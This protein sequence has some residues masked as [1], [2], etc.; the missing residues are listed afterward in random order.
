[1]S[2]KSLRSTKKILLSHSE[3]NFS[4]LDL[5]K[6]AK[7]SWDK[8]S[9]EFDKRDHPYEASFLMLDSAKA[10]KLLHWQTVWG[11]KKTVESTILWYKTFYEKRILTTETILL[12]YISDAQKKNIPWSKI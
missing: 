9:F 6:E 8:I 12:E 5:V 3:N 4:V 1:M 2:K 10:N 11:F 7:K